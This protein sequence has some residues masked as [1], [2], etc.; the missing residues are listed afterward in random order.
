MRLEAN[1]TNA[2][3]LDVMMKRLGNRQS[4][5]VRASAVWEL[6]R[7]I[8]QL[9][10]GAILP[11]FLEKEHQFQTVVGEPRYDLPADFLRE[12]EEGA[13]SFYY[14]GS[15]LLRTS[16]VAKEDLD[17]SSAEP[18][19]GYSLFGGKILIAPKPDVVYDCVWEYYASS[20]EVVD[21]AQA[22]ANVWLIYAYNWVTNA[23]LE[24]IAAFHLQAPDMASGF[25][26]KAREARD[27]VWRAHEARQHTNRDYKIED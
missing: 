11:W 23:A 5:V 25:A 18:T 20:S 19:V 7:A 10:T 12:Y 3:V 14:Q 6:N 13:L 15:L 22:V 4:P 9:E 8:D 26:A 1:T 27:A 21:N 24:Q 16:K 17:Y 2:Q